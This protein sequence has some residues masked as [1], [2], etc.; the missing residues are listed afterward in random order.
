[1]GNLCG[2]SDSKKGDDEQHLLPEDAVESARGDNRGKR[3]PPGAR[4]GAYGSVNGGG[5]GGGRDTGG[6]GNT[7][8]AADQQARN[9]GGGDRGGRGGGGDSHRNGNGDA[10]GAAPAQKKDGPRARTVPAGE[11]VDGAATRG[12]RPGASTTQGAVDKHSSNEKFYVVSDAGS[13]SRKPF[14]FDKTKTLRPKKRHKRGTKR[15]ELHQTIRA[16]LG[17][18]HVDMLEVVKL[19]DGVT[20]PEWVAVHVI[21]FYNEICLLYGT[22]GDVCTGGSC[23]VMSAGRKYTYL[24]ADGVTVKTPIKVPA[25]EYVDYLMEWVD[26]Q[27]SNER[28]FPVTDGAVGNSGAQ[29]PTNFMSHMKVIFKRLFRVYAHMYHSHFK[30]FVDLTAEVHLNTCFKR[31]VF[32]ILEFELVQDKELAPLRDLIDSLLEGSAAGHRRGMTG[33]HSIPTDTTNPDDGGA[34]HAAEGEPPAPGS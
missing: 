2:G 32:F 13:V 8:A 3:D 10:G 17:S 1:M 14:T 15:Y 18:R 26:A 24:W 5:R 31:F 34:P 33:R 23:P 19:P 4:P 27:I 21:D 29:Y 11:R 7:R 28:L 20:K 6:G 30:V 9:G 22:I 12:T 25:P 16:T